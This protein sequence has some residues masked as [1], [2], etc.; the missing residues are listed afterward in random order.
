MLKNVL[1]SFYGLQ[2][3]LEG[4]NSRTLAIRK[5]I[6]YVVKSRQTKA[7]WSLKCNLRGVYR[8]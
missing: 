1:P 7:K 4:D 8:S 6:K 5:S 3:R 2:C